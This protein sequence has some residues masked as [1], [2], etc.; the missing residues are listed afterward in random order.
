MCN[1]FYLAFWSKA[2]NRRQFFERY[3]RENQF[4]PRLPEN[5]YMQSRQKIIQTKVFTFFKIL[6]VQAEL[7]IFLGEKCTNILAVGLAS[8]FVFAFIWGKEN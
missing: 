2:S 7:T 5:W 6:I 1:T 3:A 8:L 4:D